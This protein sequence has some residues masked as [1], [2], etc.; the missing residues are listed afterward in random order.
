MLRYTVFIVQA[1][2]TS[3]YVV[4]ASGA[5]LSQEVP[6]VKWMANQPALWTPGSMSTPNQYIRIILSIRTV[7]LGVCIFKSIS[8][9]WVQTFFLP[10]DLHFV[11][12]HLD[13]IWREMRILR[14]GS[15]Y[16]VLIR[17]YHCRHINLMR[18]IRGSRGGGYEGFCFLEFK[19]L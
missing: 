7:L 5:A 15:Q 9:L 6:M 8:S 18:R 4:P 17:M 11:R 19:A 12:S 16:G 1:C 13:F 14:Y 3:Q 2:Q 10:S